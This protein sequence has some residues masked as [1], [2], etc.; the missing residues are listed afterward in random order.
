MTDT[1]EKP[2]QQFDYEV[3][4]KGRPVPGWYEGLDEQQYRKAW[5]AANSDLLMIEKSPA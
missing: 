4:D 1:E 5:A 3:D 2:D